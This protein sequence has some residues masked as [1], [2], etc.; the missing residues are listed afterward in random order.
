MSPDSTGPSSA[1]SAVAGSAVLT[2]GFSGTEEAEGLVT[3]VAIGAGLIFILMALLR[4]GWISQFI[5]RAVITGFL[6]ER[7]L[8]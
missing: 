8:T 7:Q 5:S 1:L 6:F 3:A 4:L 2:A